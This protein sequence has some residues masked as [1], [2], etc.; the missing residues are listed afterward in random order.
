MGRKMSVE[1][2]TDLLP[3]YQ[4]L[5]S[6]GIAVISQPW[7]YIDFFFKRWRYYKK[8]IVSVNL[9]SD[10]SKLVSLIF[11]YV[12]FN[13]KLLKRLKVSYKFQLIKKKVESDEQ[14][15]GE[16]K[17]I[18]IDQAISLVRDKKFTIQ[19]LEDEANIMVF[20]AFETTASILYSILMC[21]SFYPE[22]QEKL[23]SEIVSVL[24]DEK[25]VTFEDLGNLTYTEM[26]I[27]ESLRL[28]PAVPFVGRRTDRDL[29]LSKT[30]FLPK[31]TELII[32]IFHIQRNKKY[33]GENSCTFNPDNFL[34]ENVSYRSSYAFMPFSKGVRNCIGRQYAMFSIKVFFLFV[35]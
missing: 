6:L 11:F 18:F 26:V 14:G 25:E 1:G 29:H 28:L 27:F 30:L 2:E 20:G 12:T 31:S 4:T 34:P 9:V 17:S 33:W 5:L 7:L 24:P 22:Y 19:E 35:L 13:P 8:A 23:Y 21:L 3:H 32:S 10:F 15:I 16:P